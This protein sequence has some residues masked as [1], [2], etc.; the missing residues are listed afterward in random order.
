M[1]IVSCVFL[2]MVDYTGSKSNRI[3]FRL[4]DIAFSCDRS[5]FAETAAK[6]APQAATF[7]KIAFMT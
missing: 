7:M 2:Q 4:E 5:I 6:Y 1:I 3:P